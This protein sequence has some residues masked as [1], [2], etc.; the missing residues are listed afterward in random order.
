MLSATYAQNA[1]TTVKVNASATPLD[2]VIMLYDGAI[3]FLNKASFYM[4]QR[5]ISR[6]IH[7][8]SKVAAI[9]EELL[10]SLNMEAG[11]EVAANLQDLYFYILKELTI[12]NAN[13]DVEKVKHISELLKV[14]REGWSEIK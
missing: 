14:L 3:N 10:A 5:E 6:K 1:Y 2:L 7:Y 4:N 9:I 12:A 11:G 8:V 13:N